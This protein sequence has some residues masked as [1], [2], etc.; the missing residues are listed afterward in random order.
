MNTRK[1]GGLANK[2]YAA[3]EA[4]QITPRQALKLLDPLVDYFSETQWH[5]YH[6]HV[7]FYRDNPWF[8]D[9]A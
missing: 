9:K 4:K 6:D 3:L 8:L 1:A 7:R 5:K 2:V